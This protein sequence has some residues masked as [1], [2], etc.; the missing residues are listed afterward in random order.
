M[1]DIAAVI[2]RVN[3]ARAACSLAPIAELPEGELGNP[4]FCPLGRAFRK[5]MGDSFFLAVGSKH[6]RLATTDGSASTIAQRIR[7]AWG[8]KDSRPGRA[9]EEFVII[10]LPSALTQFVMEFDA[11]KLPKFEGKIE[12]AE[13]LLLNNLARRLWNVTIG[14][15][16]RVRQLTRRERAE[17]SASP[18]IPRNSQ[19]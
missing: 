6:I 17:T 4:C 15:L 13:K 2:A 14:R 1:A 19:P 10:P 8:A 3:A 7:E 9:G 18:A 16:R 12:E 5:D 11:G